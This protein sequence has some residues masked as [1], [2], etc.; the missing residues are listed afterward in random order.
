MVKSGGGELSH[1]TNFLPFSPSLR[2]RL[3]CSRISRGD[4][5]FPGSCHG[6]CD[7]T[8]RELALDVLMEVFSVRLSI[9]RLRNSQYGTWEYSYMP[10]L[11]NSIVRVALE[12][13]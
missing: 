4:G 12:S 3:S 2:R 7:P 9:Q 8:I 5:P 11:R 10:P 1:P 6:L 13:S